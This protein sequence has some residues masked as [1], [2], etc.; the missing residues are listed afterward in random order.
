MK[1]IANFINES[2]K[3]KVSFNAKSDI[4]DKDMQSDMLYTLSNIDIRRPNPYIN[5][6]DVRVNVYDKPKNITLLNFTFIMSNNDVIEC[7]TKS[8]T[9]ED[10]QLIT[11]AV[12]TITI[13]D[14]T[15]KHSVDMSEILDINDIFARLVSFIKTDYV[16]YI[17]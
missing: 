13:N 14:D 11:D 7:I 16:K 9:P 2:K 4:F 12:L 17:K 15:I 6:K 1:T 10:E 8:T 3:T 5:V